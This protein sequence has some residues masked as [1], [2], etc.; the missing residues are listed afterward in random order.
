MP[1][2]RISIEQRLNRARVAI[3]NVLADSHLQAAVAAYGYTYAR[4]DQGRALHDAAL[5]LDQQQKDIYGGLFSAVDTLDAARRQAND[6]F[7]RHVKV[8]RVA[9]KQD[10][11]AQQRLGLLAQRKHTLAGWQS[12]AGQFYANARAN[13]DI[14]DRLGAFGI[15][16]EM[17]AEGQR[18]IDAVG[19]GHAARQHRKGAAQDTT[20][21]RDEALA[22]LDAWMA[23]FLK[24]AQVAL[25]DR[26]QLLAQLGLAAASRAPRQSAPA[27]AAESVRKPPLPTATIAAA[28]SPAGASP[29]DGGQLST[30]A[31]RNGRA[32]VGEQA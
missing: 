16:E 23:D 15:S 10:R 12:Q 25:Q 2:R 7:M 30:A 27:P 8:A 4:L 6:T 5:A 24:I 18:L 32:A 22:A 21:A 29:D 19:Q 3:A 13:P 9:L 31:R 11:G 1:Q 20:R 28:P 14:L 26:P 17:L